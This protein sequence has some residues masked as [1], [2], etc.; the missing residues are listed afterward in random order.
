MAKDDKIRHE[1]EIVTEKNL[2]VSTYPNPYKTEFK[3]NIVA[4]VNGMATIQLYSLNGVKIY[5]MKQYLVAGKSIVTD[6]NSLNTFETGII[7]KV[8]I[9]KY[10]TSGILL[11]L[12]K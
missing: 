3:L 7:Y 8:S 12:S 9:D 11:R 2:I 4:P 6:I 10:Q 1:K 5:E